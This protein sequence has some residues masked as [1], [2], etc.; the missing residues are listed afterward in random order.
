[1]EKFLIKY[2]LNKELRYPKLIE[3]VIKN[4]L[5]IQL[6]NNIIQYK[7]QLFKNK[8]HDEKKR[9]PAL[10]W[11]TFCIIFFFRLLHFRF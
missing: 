3:S 8:T 9:F 5:E 1:M 4:I 11:F 2:I 7:I 10:Y 6:L